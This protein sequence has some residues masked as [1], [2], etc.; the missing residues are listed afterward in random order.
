[1]EI[2]LFS[3]RSGENNNE[4]RRSEE[5]EKVDGKEVRVFL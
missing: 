1:M 5:E 4:L 3:W 2:N